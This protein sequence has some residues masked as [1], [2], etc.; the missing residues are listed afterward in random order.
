MSKSAFLKGAIWLT[1]ATFLSKVLGSAFRIPLQNIAGDEVLGI[2]SVVYPVYMSI[3]T[4]TVAGIPLAIS[5]LISIARGEGREGDVYLIYRTAAILGIVFGLVSFSLMFGFAETIAGTLG[6]SLVTSSIMAVSLTLIFAPYMA[7]FRGFFQ[8]FED[9]IPTAVSQVL[10]Q[11]LRVIVIL[12]AAVYLTNRAYSSELVSGGVMIGS[13]VGVIASL[14]YLQIVFAKRKLLPAKKPKFTFSEFTVWAKRILIISLPICFGALTMALLNVVDSL[15]VPGQLASLG[16]TE[17]EIAYLYGIYG[18]GQA[19][20]QIAVVFASALILPLIPAITKALAEQKRD[21][22]SA[23]INKATTFTHI[24]S[25]PVAV[26]LAVITWPLNYVLFG[27]TLGSD[28]IFVLS[29]SALFTAFSVLTT[30]M[31][32]GANR[33]RAAAIIV[34]IFSIIKVVLNIVLVSRFGIIGAAISTLLT[35]ILMTGANMLTLYKTIPFVLVKRAHLVFAGASLVMGGVLVC[36]QW[37]L[38]TEGWSRGVMAIYMLA[39]IGVG[40]VIYAS[41]LVIFKGID[42]ELL[43]SLPFVSKFIKRGTKH[44]TEQVRKDGMKQER[45]VVKLLKKG[46]WVIVII[47]LLASAPSLMKRVQVEQENRPYEVAMPYE[48]F[49]LW[50]DMLEET[51]SVEQALAELKEN[52]LTSMSI[53]PVTIS[54]LVVDGVFE[55]I[56]RT[57]IEH[58]HPEAKG[59]I[60]KN[61]GQFVK[62]LEKENEYINIVEEVYNNHY[63]IM[64]EE[65]ILPKHLKVSFHAYGDDSY[66]FLPYEVSLSAMPLGFD[67]DVLEQI[68]GAGLHIIP[69][70]PDRFMNIQNENHYV[71]DMMT[72]LAEDYGAKTL[73]FTGNEVVGSGDP[74]ELKAFAQKVKELGFSVVSI[75]FNPQRGMTSLLRVGDLEEDVIRLFSMTLGKGEEATYPQEVEKGVRGYKERNIRLMYVNP[76]KN[77]VTGSQSYNHP[78]EAERGYTLT[79]EMIDSLTSELGKEYNSQAVPFES[80]SQ[81]FIVKVL[82][83]IGAAAF[84]AL[85]GLQFHL[86]IGGLAGLGGLGLGVL[87]LVPIDAAWKGLALLVAIGGAVYAGMAVRSI[88]GWKQLIG[89]YALSA[90][91]ALTGAWFVIALLYGPTFL[92]KVDEFRGVK[93]LAALPVLVVGFYLF[94]S[95]LKKLM[96]EPVRYWHLAIMLFITGA[97]GFYVWRTGNSAMTLPYELEFRN[98]LESVLYVRPRTSEFLIGFPLFALGLYLRMRKSKVAPLFITLGML[99]FA[100]MVGTFTHLHTALLISVLRT[101]YGLAFGFL[102]G[103]V[104]IQVYRLIERYIYPQVKKRWIQ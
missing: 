42:Q 35:Y 39:L 46:L 97:L 52:G 57:E 24:T 12:V 60:P 37:F 32:Q 70:L 29:V 79:L 82:V 103:L 28:V 31:L 40:A 85:T 87:S 14:I 63:T 95:F 19:L 11:F 55:R 101:V 74:E 21:Q 7:V 45:G 50:P 86:I 16:N 88:K 58:E 104:F 72:M 8:G 2:F 91:I 34:L 83:I 53:E 13:V 64:K 100:S 102:I 17:R 54:D 43:Q 69:R 38:D 56:G 47:A 94:A 3:L 68:K 67:R 61:N 23:I 77:F 99:G 98:W 5:K 93:I 59:E 92:V 78:G 48:Q 6:G 10:E 44:E 75:D 26:G 30:G 84:L 20:V 33:E 25:W 96:G 9:M 73:S 81:P 15:T 66:L 51:L 90:A 36:I 1:I 62:I 18:R 4:L 80:F 22:A 27:D 65:G 76:V 89:A 49:V 41:L 71:Y